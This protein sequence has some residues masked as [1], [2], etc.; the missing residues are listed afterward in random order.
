MRASRGS[1]VV[2]PTFEQGG[3]FYILPDTM[4]LA[5]AFPEFVESRATAQLDD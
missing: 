4:S 5:E 1:G 3:V 2:Q